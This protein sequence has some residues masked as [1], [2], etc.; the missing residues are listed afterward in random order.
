MISDEVMK[1]VGSYEILGTLGHS[2]MVP[3]GILGGLFRGG[4]QTKACGLVI[5][6]KEVIIKNP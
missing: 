3:S 6:R 2:R 1:K 5:L 4:Y